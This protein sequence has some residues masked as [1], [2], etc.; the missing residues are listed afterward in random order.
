MEVKSETDL[1]EQDQFHF[2]LPSQFPKLD[3]SYKGWLS[4]SYKSWPEWVL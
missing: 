1:V 4:E 3:M 2:S